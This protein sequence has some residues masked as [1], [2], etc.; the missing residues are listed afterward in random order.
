MFSHKPIRYK[1]RISTNNHMIRQSISQYFY[2]SPIGTINLSIIVVI[3]L[4][5]STASIILRAMRLIIRIII[6]VIRTGMVDKIGIY[7]WIIEI[8][9]IYIHPSVYDL[10]LLLVILL[11]MR[12]LLR[13]LWTLVLLIVCIRQR[14]M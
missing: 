13:I 8:I 10:L 7:V 11:M 5:I 3:A 9:L 6:A 12:V 1:R 14:L 2:Q 4:I